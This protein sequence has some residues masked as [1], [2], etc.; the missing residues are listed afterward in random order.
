M[1]I[2][3]IV[4]MVPREDGA[5]AIPLLLHA[6]LAGLRQEH[7]V[8]LVTAVGDEAGEV[9]A[10]ERLL[11]SGLDARVADRRQ[12]RRV[13]ARW[14]RRVRLASAWL[15]SRRPWRTIWFADPGVQALLDDLSA[16]R[17]FD[18]VAVEDSAMSVYR[19]P[20]GVPTILTE[21]EAH[22][23]AAPGWLRG[24]LAG[25]PRQALRSLDWRRAAGFQER[26]W[27][28]FDRI[29]VFC[30]GDAEAIAAVNPALASRIDVNPFGIELPPAADA[31][32]QEPDTVVFVGNFTHPPNRDAAIWLAREIMPAVRARTAGARLRIIGSAPPAEVTELAG[33][34]VEVVAD[35]PSVAPHLEAASVV[36]APVRSGGGMRMKILEAIAREKAVV[37]TPLGAEGFTEFDTQPPL[38]IGEGAAELAV[39]TAEL[40]ADPAARQRL[41]RAARSFAEAH[42]APR[43]WAERL[44][45]VYEKTIASRG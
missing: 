10:V 13:L 42:Y 6:E 1:R 26:A 15:F 3:L 43:A 18:V 41:G 9:E 34:D 2:L 20:A 31:E 23:V 12:P 7:E 8:T 36:L 30:R 22:R 11:A 21:H 14:R 39:L 29:Q 37:T 16:E 19:L 33:P 27:R 5:G 35:A 28:R 24:S 45:A 32:R 44:T 40:L 4:P 25:L 17:E 38:R